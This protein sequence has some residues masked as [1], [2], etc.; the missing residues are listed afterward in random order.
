MYGWTSAKNSLYSNHNDT[1]SYFLPWDMERFTVCQQL[2]AMSL[3]Q[4]EIPVIA[5]KSLNLE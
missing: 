4:D 3:Q 1:Y 2:Q 5:V